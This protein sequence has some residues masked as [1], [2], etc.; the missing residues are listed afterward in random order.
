MRI[1]LLLTAYADGDAVGVLYGENPTELPAGYGPNLSAALR[2]LADQIEKY[3]CDATAKDFED[4]AY[5]K[6]K[7]HDAQ[8]RALGREPQPKMVWFGNHRVES[9]KGHDKPKKGDAS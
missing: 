9:L 7:C 1:P 5:L 4:A 3:R 6:T 8:E 2:D